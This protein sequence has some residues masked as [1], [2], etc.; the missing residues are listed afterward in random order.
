MSEV[1]HVRHDTARAVNPESRQ[2]S[3]GNKPLGTLSGLLIT[4][5]PLGIGMIGVVRLIKGTTTEWP[6]TGTIMATRERICIELMTSGRK[7]KASREGS[8]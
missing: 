4:S 8:K 1:P 2:R 6:W 7:L 3:A 5:H